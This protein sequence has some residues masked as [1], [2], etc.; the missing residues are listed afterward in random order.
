M[1]VIASYP[2]A[3]GRPALDE[4]HLRHREAPA[5]AVAIS[6]SRH[7]DCFAA[8]AM[9]AKPARL[10]DRGFLRGAER[11]SNLVDEL[12]SIIC[13]VAR[14]EA[15]VRAAAAPAQEIYPRHPAAQPKFAENRCRRFDGAISNNESCAP[16]RGGDPDK[17]FSAHC[18]QNSRCG[19]RRRTHR[20]TAAVAAALDG[21]AVPDASA[22]LGLPVWL[23]F[24]VGKAIV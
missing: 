24:L 16:V 19:I 5:G 9:T 10:M 18:Q 15:K 11:Q 12:S 21:M 3:P 23:V 20:S 22:F 14:A 17:R 8:L 7:R 13:G 6:K 1:A 2:P 4:T